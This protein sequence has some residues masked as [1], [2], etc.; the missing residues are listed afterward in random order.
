MQS[1]KWKITG[2]YLMLFITLAPY[3]YGLGDNWAHFENGM[4]YIKS[5]DY[6]RALDNF[7]YYL[8]QPEMHRHMFGVAYFGRGVLYESRKNYG[9]AI[10]EYRLAIENDLHPSVKISDKAYMNIG[11]IYMGRKEYEDAIRA[12][13]GAVE[14]NKQSG[15]AHYYLGLAYLRAGQYEQAEKESEEAKNLGVTFTALA[16]ELN[17]AKG[18]SP[19]KGN[20]E[21]VN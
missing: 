10:A 1:I 15:L 13:A 19:D 14:S 12:Y 9:Q 8:H 21:K 4:K 6:S 11:T 3:A 16:D 17:K 7:N 18:P 2:I 20:A 5:G